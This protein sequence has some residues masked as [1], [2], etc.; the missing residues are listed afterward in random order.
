MSS[1]ESYAQTADSVLLGSLDYHLPPGAPYIQDRARAQFQTSAAG[2]FSFSGVRT[3]RIPITSDHA[4]ADLSTARLSFRIKNAS[5]ATDRLVANGERTLLKPKCGPWGLIYRLQ[6]FA[7]GVPVTDTVNYGRLH[8]MMYLLSPKDWKIQEA[9]NDWITGVDDDGE[10]MTGEIGLGDAVTVSMP[11]IDGLMQCGKFWPCKFAPLVLA[12]ELAPADWCWRT[13]D[14]VNTSATANDGTALTGITKHFVSEYVLEDPRIHVDMVTL[15]P[16]LT[17]EYTALMLQGKALTVPINM[18]ITHTQQLLGNNPVLSITRAASRLRHIFWS[19][20]G[21]GLSAATR[22]VVSVVNDFSHPKRLQY[23]QDGAVSDSV[24]F[25]T[26][27]I[28][29]HKKLPEYP[30]RRLHEYWCELRKCLGLMW[31]KEEPLDISMLQYLSDRFIGGIDC[32]RA[33]GVSWTGLN[34]RSGDLLTLEL[35][36]I[37]VPATYGFPEIASPEKQIHVTLV[38]EAIV[39]IQNNTVSVFD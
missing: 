26:Q 29:G 22:R 14:Q 9:V 17:N 23:M 28:L 7:A 5:T 15:D 37:F 31:D 12:V 39:S 33:L 13:Y 4:F 20:E 6:L 25:E 36:D 32:E 10:F 16:G 21:N 24:N 11:I 2:S 8:E 19:F 38:A 30:L 27:W 1:L 3:F 18:Y 35:K 34:S